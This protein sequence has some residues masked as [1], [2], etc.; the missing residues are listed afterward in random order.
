MLRRRRFRTQSSA[1]SLR[2][3][4]D[5]TRSTGPDSTL[6]IHVLP[7]IASDSF[8]QFLQ[9]AADHELLKG[10]V[11]DA[12]QCFQGG[13]SSSFQHLQV[14]WY[15]WVVECIEKSYWPL[16]ESVDDCDCTHG[17]GEIGKHHSI[18]KIGLFLS[19]IRPDSWVF[20]ER[21]TMLTVMNSQVRKSLF[22]VRHHQAG[23]HSHFSH[24]SN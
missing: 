2:T 19:A 22:E 1:F 21:L 8:V 12:W 18:H 5:I 23:R 6:S 7:W 14:F 13:Q 24:T 15:L 11:W 17:W 10:V 20:N 16:L 9:A 4:Q 3:C